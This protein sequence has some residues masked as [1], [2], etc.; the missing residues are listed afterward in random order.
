MTVTDQIKILDKKIKQNEAQYDLDR[1]AAKISALSSNNLDKYEYL[2]GEDLGLKPSTVEQAKFE[3]S[4]LG[5]IFNKGL[6]EEDRKE[7]LFKRIK[8]IEGKSEEQLNAIEDQGKKQLEEIKNINASS[9]PLKT[10]V[11]LVQ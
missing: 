9:K 2:T 4:P 1:E 7:G 8:N 11:F 10:I 3:Y 6:S 5:E